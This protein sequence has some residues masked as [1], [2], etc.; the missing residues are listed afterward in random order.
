VKDQWYCGVDGQQYGPYTWDQLRAMAA[1][2][3]IVPATYVRREIDEQWVSAARIPGLLARG[4]PVAKPA[5]PAAANGSSPSGGSG[6]SKKLKAAKPI[7]VTATPAAAPPVSGSVVPVG[8]PVPA[9]PVVVPIAPVA[10]GAPLGFAINTDPATKAPAAGDDEL[11]PRK[12]GSPLVL[13]GVLGGAALAVAIVGIGL[14]AWTWSQSP[15]TETDGLAATEPAGEFEDA[16]AGSAA[17]SKGNQGSSAVKLTDRAA[18]SGQSAA[19]AK[20]VLAAQ[21]RWGNVERYSI[22]INDVHLKVTGVWLAADESGTWVEPK[23]P[24]APASAPAAD[25]AAPGKFLFVEVRLFNGG[26]VPRKFRSWNASDSLAA[27]MADDEGDVLTPVPA[28]QTPGVPRLSS[29]RLL[30]NQAVNDT[31]VFEA[32]DDPFETLRLAISRSALAESMRGYIA[33]EVP[34]DVLFRKRDQAAADEPMLAAD[35]SPPPGEVAGGTALAGAGGG[36]DAKM[37][38]KTGKPPS[39]ADLN[40]QFEELDKATKAGDPKPDPA[41]LAETAKP[42]AP[43]QPAEPENPFKPVAPATPATPTQPAGPAAA[44]PPAVP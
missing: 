3:R 17:N 40:K 7:V 2:G 33:F 43:P 10:S 38:A 1:E 8:Q 42:M 19:A 5:A 30:P 28:A 23:L 18:T 14:V 11:E 31:L 34:V 9:A 24:D 12:K 37:P 39:V 22:K 36:G 4:K 44:A 20:K 13:V 35:P 27:V 6:T 41:K 16:E 15:V 32:P 21:A 25:S 26:G 29:L